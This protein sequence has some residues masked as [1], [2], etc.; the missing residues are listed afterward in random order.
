MTDEELDEEYKDACR[1]I[2]QQAAGFGLGIFHPAFTNSV[3][4]G[5]TNGAPALTIPLSKIRDFGL[6]K[7]GQSA[8]AAVKLDM[9]RWEKAR[10]LRFSALFLKS[11]DDQFA[12]DR[13]NDKDTVSHF[14]VIVTQVCFLGL[15]CDSKKDEDV[16]PSN[17]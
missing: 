1:K 17:R 15:L 11:M 12:P 9:V 16:I 14:A 4:I 7:A 6:G 10:R 5:V 13:I 3:T 2:G 8:Y